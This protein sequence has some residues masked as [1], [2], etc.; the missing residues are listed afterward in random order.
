M[1]VILVGVTKAILGVTCTVWLPNYVGTDVTLPLSARRCERTT[2]QRVPRGMLV[3]RILFPFGTYSRVSLHGSQRM[4]TS[5]PYNVGYTIRGI[6][7]LAR[8]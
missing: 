1:K 7:S 2:D 6:R 5:V 8:L 4:P 3:L